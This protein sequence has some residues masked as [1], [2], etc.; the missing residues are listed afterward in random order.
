MDDTKISKKEMGEA[1][2]VQMDD[3]LRTLLGQMFENDNDTTYLRAKLKAT[4]GSISEL[5]FMIRITA[6]DGISTR[7]E[8]DDNG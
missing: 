2:D 8:D 3:F 1:E 6:V 5:E 7:D 4:D